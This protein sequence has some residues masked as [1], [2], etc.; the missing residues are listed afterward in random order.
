M[1]H[2]NYNKL[3]AR[4]LYINPRWLY[5]G[6]KF[7][8]VRN[9]GSKFRSG[10]IQWGRSPVREGFSDSSSHI[11]EVATLIPHHQPQHQLLQKNTAPHGDVL[12]VP[13][14]LLVAPSGG[15]WHWWQRI[16]RDISIAIS[17]SS[18]HRLSI[19]QVSKSHLS[20]QPS[21]ISIHG[22]RRPSI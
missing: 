12:T 21:W 2:P 3:S 10:I 19:S 7:R 16:L 22:I 8:I 18:R 20:Q 9:C 14:V 1:V 15:Q 5:V 6:R 11:L 4:V 13:A 17:S